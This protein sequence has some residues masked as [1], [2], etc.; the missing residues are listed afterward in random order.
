MTDPSSSSPE[1]PGSLTWIEHVLRAERMAM[2]E[3]LTRRLA[4]FLADLKLQLGSEIPRV[5]WPSAAEDTA[6]SAALKDVQVQVFP[7]LPVL[8][9]VAPGQ[10]L[11][12]CADGGETV[13]VAQA[14][15]ATATEV[16]LEAHHTNEVV[17]MGEAKAGMAQPKTSP[18]S[19]KSPKHKHRTNARRSSHAGA[20]ILDHTTGAEETKDKGFLRN[21]VD[22]PHFETSFACL[23]IANALVMAV[24]AQYLGIGLG[25]DIGF[26]G[27]IRPADDAWPNAAAFFFALE[28]IFGIAFT[29]E[30]IMKLIALKINFFLFYWN[31]IDTAILVFWYLDM[32][33]SVSLFPNPML[34]R[35]ARLGKMVRLIRLVKT[36]EAFDVLH[37]LVA[38][39]TS[40][41]A[42][43]SWSLLF[44]VLIMSTGALLMSFSLQSFVEDTSNPHDVRLKA[45]EYFGTF[46]RAFLT[47]F[48]ITVGNWVPVCRFLHESIS[49]WFLLVLLIYRC[50]V[51]FAVMN[52]I[53]AIFLHETFKVAASDDHLMITQQQRQLQKDRKKMTTLLSLADENGDGCISREQFHRI[54]SEPRVLIWL[55]AMQLDLRG[56]SSPDFLF[57]MAD[58]QGTNYVAIDGLVRAFESLKG[59]AR[60]IDM[61]IVMSELHRIEKNL[62]ET[63]HDKQ[64]KVPQAAKTVSQPC[65]L[66]VLLEETTNGGVPVMC[67]L[68]PVEAQGRGSPGSAVPGIADK[69]KVRRSPQA[70]LEKGQLPDW[71]AQ[72]SSELGTEGGV[73]DA[74]RPGPPLLGEETVWG[75]DSGAST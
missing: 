65:Q 10:G 5:A 72:M 37:L 43:L 25:Y 56:A 15:K 63:V 33:S 71:L 68:V 57:D 67:R 54:L 42:V 34:L 60:S 2:D 35:L 4:E 46:S 55:E 26:P 53:R 61:E 31:W 23:I 45:F 58:D 66:S 74:P 3:L 47:M 13:L 24:E 48:E 14:K 70:V 50:L 41:V 29:I 75:K 22:G 18:R 12:V 39:I 9:G 73:A 19:P 64:G 30:A 1:A 20:T 59:P 62:I 16:P 44:L 27:S 11:Q 49:E 21:I 51:G 17:G 52:V 8:P 36:I 32:T 7:V 28:L 40:S 69:R 6:S 38:S